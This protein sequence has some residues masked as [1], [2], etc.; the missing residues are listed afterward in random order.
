MRSQ[1]YEKKL[2]NYREH[3]Y[4]LMLNKQELITSK[5]PAYKKEAI[6]VSIAETIELIDHASNATERLI[7]IYKDAEK[8]HEWLQIIDAKLEDVIIDSDLP[9]ASTTYVNHRLYSL[10]EQIQDLNDL[11]LMQEAI[12]R[13][14]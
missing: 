13:T 3:K 7:N 2:R 1:E 14:R 11:I 8:E 10:G 4:K 6:L 5:L 9:K 12:K